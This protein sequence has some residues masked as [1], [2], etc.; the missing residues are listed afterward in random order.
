MP[1]LDYSILQVVKD[2]THYIY[3][4]AHSPLGLFSNWYITLTYITYIAW[5]IYLYKSWEVIYEQR[6]RVDI[7]VRHE[8]ELFIWLLKLIETDL[9]R[10]LNQA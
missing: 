1:D 3:Y 9:N 7:L 10:I 8:L 4:S 6:E 5:T 2:E